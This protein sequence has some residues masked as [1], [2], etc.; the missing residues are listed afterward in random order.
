MEE[1]LVSVI[2]EGPDPIKPIRDSRTNQTHNF[3]RGKALEVSAEFAK[4][5]IGPDFNSRGFTADQLDLARAYD[6]HI[7]RIVGKERAA[8]LK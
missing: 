2:Y 5:L 7:F 3:L 1:E 4:V 6:H 8:P